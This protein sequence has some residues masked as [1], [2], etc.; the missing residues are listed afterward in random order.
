MGPPADP[1]TLLGVPRDAGAAEIRAA[2]RRAALRCHPDSAGPA[3]GAEAAREFHRLTEAY[4]TLLARHGEGRA[5]GPGEGRPFTPQDFT[6]MEVGWQDVRSARGRADADGW[7]PPGTHR[8]SC[9]TRNEG[10]I[11]VWFWLVAVALAVAAAWAVIELRVFGRFQ[12]DLGATGVAA[13]VA[14]SLAVYAVT[15]VAALAALMATR[16]FVWLVGRLGFTG[17]RTLPEPREEG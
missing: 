8:V 2:Y 9:A 5:A 10:R 4:R 6:R 15:V 16:R 1:Y 11:F 13:V 14:M 17:R 3:K 12:E 7:V